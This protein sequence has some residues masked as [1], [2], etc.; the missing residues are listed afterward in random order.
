MALALH[1][2]SRRQESNLP[3]ANFLLASRVRITWHLYRA[4]RGARLFFWAT[5]CRWG[6]APSR[7]RLARESKR[8][9]ADVLASHVHVTGGIYYAP[10]SPPAGAILCLW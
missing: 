6:L 1:R 5:P 10:R 8:D 9:R 4:P 7:T 2:E 3:Q